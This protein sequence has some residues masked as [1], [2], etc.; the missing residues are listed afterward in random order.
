MPDELMY[1]RKGTWAFILAAAAAPIG[2]LLSGPCSS[3][4]CGACPASGACLLMFPV[5]I[6]G[7]VAVKSAR[8]VKD[9]FSGLVA[10]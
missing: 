4:A 9:F 8:A 3:G 10:K 1:K 6:V 2:Y 7:V 5:I